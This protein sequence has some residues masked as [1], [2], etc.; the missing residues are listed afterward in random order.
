[1]TTPE[2]EWGGGRS[3][4]RVKIWTSFG[5]FC[6]CALALTFGHWTKSIEY[7]LLGIAVLIPISTYLVRCERCR[8]AEVTY[9]FGDRPRAS[10]GNLLMP[11]KHCPKCGLERI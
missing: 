10:S 2:A 7:T 3:L 5:L 1:M 4:V 11:A 9:R 8:Q 6:A